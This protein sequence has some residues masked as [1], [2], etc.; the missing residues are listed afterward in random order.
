MEV[1]FPFLYLQNEYGTDTA[2]P[3]KWRGS[4][5]HLMVRKA[6]TDPVINFIQLQHS[7]MPLLGFAGGG[8]SAGNLY[9]VDYGGA[10]PEKIYMAKDNYLQKA[11]EAVFSRKQGG[12][13]WGN[14]FERDPEAVRL[15]VLNELVSIDRAALDY[16][17]VIDKET[18]FV[19]VEATR[20][21]RAPALSASTQS[22][23]AL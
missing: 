17:V 12:G 13:G 22:G 4:P 7:R 8:E 20:V 3:G 18:L 6:T 21:R 9:I 15:D 2:A 10:H 14:P 16:G 1:L 11:G 5:A 19:D 23:E